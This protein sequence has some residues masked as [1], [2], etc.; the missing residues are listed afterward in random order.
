MFHHYNGKH[1]VVRAVRALSVRAR[2]GI[3]AAAL[4]SLSVAGLALSGS[5]S[6]ATAN[7]GVYIIAPKWWGWCPNVAGQNNYP[8]YMS[9]E[10]Y[11]TGD[12][13][14][15]AGDDVIWS[16]VTLNQ[17]NRIE[18]QVGCIRGYYSTG[19]SVTIRP[20]RNGQSWDIS[21]SGATWHN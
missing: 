8:Y 11:T 1:A 18:V 6:A 15:D 13:S 14:A 9:Q 10:N 5:A 4:A 19:T 7:G 17:N 3:I 16:R 2:I 21:P 12:S 20:T